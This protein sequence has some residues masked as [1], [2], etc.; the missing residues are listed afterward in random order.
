MSGFVDV[1]KKNYSISKLQ[2]ESG[3]PRASSPSINIANIVALLFASHLS[4]LLH[5]KI[6]STCR[7]EIVFFCECVCVF[8]FFFNLY[9]KFQDSG[10]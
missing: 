1:Y 4:S 5:S 10:S 7:K 9:I 8:F 3:K 6:A 2:K